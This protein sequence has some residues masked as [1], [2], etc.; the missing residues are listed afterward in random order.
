[1]N[2]QSLAVFSMPERRA[3]ALQGLPRLILRLEALTVLGAAVFSYRLIG[4]SW[5]HFGALFLLPDLSMLA[6]FWGSRVGAFA[7]NVTHSYVSAAIL[8]GIGLLIASQ[9]CTLAALIWTAH[10]GFDRAL[11]YGL[12][13]ASEFKDTHLGQLGRTGPVA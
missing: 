11:G 3:L 5:V 7:Y 4:G 1:M 8:A 12:K 10:I 6:Y 13:Y 2:I 9:A